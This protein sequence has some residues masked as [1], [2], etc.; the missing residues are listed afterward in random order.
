MISQACQ[1]FF[2][3]S[4]DQIDP[5]NELF[6][7]LDPFWNVSPKDII[8]GVTNMFID[9]SIHHKLFPMITDWKFLWNEKEKLEKKEEK[10]EEM[11]KTKRK[12][13]GITGKM[14]SGKNTVCDMIIAETKNRF[15]EYSFALP[16]KLGCQILFDFSNDQIF[17]DQKEQ[18]DSRYQTTPRNILQ[19]IGTEMFRDSISQY[20]PKIHLYSTLWVSNLAKEILFP[21][22]DQDIIISDLRFPDELQFLRLINAK[23]IK[24]IRPN[25]E[26]T[27][28][29][30]VSESYLL[31]TDM[32]IKNNGT[33]ENLKEQVEFLSCFL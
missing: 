32:T 26:S 33:L 5:E 7:S 15:R 27:Q 12:I 20:I 11:K 3:L 14:R 8:K 6:S 13:I 29:Q 18:M 22:F 24:I 23:T 31:E 1:K 16:L 4:N 17:S 19:K 2:S 9:E 25:N 21:T 28:Q 30:H 10:K